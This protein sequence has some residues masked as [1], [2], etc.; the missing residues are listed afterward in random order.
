[1]P[2]KTTIYGFRVVYEANALEGVRHL[3]EDLDFNEAR[4]FFDQARMRGS[5]MFEDDAERQYTL[6][7][8]N[9]VY[10]LVRR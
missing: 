2:E 3:R 1:M 4:V 8:Q 6:I 9:G 10:T 5:A 7:Y